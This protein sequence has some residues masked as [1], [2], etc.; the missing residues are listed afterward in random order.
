MDDDKLAKSVVI[1][2]GQRP[3]LMLY[4]PLAVF[5]TE[6]MV[7]LALFRLI[8]FWVLTL[9]PIHFYFVVKTAEDFH[10]LTTLKADFYHW[11][12]FIKNKG[13]HGKNVVTF[14]ATPPNARKND[15]DGL[16]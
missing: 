12:L 14:C 5:L 9:I 15:Y 3:A 1:R 10:W 13:L 4:V 7:G 8:G 16:R 2:A 11:W 6:A